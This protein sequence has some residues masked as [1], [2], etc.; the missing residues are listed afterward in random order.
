MSFTVQVGVPGPQGPPGPTGPAS[1][2]GGGGGATGPTGPT[3]PD[4]ANLYPQIGT[5]AALQS[6]S[7]WPGYVAITTDT[8]LELSNGSTWTSIDTPVAVPVLPGT[9]TFAT[10]PSATSKPN[11]IAMTTDV[12]AV[13]SNGAMWQPLYNPTNSTIGIAA[14]SP[15]APA[16]TSVPYAIT[17]TASQAVGAPVWSIVFTIG[18]NTWVIDS[19]SGVL[20]GTPSAA[21]TDVVQV[22]VIDASGAS[23]QKAFSITVAASLTPAATPTFAPTAGSYTGSQSVAISCS[24]AS[25][26][27]YYTV[28]GSTPTTSSTVYT[29]PITVAVTTTIQAIA[30]ASGFTQSAVGFSAYTITVPGTTYKFHPGDY[31]VTEQVY[32]CTVAQAMTEID[33]LALHPFN[34]IGYVYGHAWYQLDTAT[35]NL[36]NP[37]NITAQFGGF[38]DIATV[39]NYLQSKIPGARFGCYINANASATSVT[40]SNIGSQNYGNGFPMPKWIANCSGSLAMPISYG[41]ATT[42]T[43]SV[44]QARG[45]AGFYGFGFLGY[46]G[47]THYAGYVAA[48]W[49]PA[50]NQAW[51]NMWEALSKWSFTVTAGPLS[52]QT[53]TLDANSL[54]E[55]L[56]VND[57]Y[58]YN[59]TSSQNAP[60]FTNNPPLQTSAANSATAANYFANHKLWAQKAT[61]FFPHTMIGL[62]DSFGFGAVGPSDTAPVMA[63]YINNAINGN[64]LST[65]Q[66][67]AYSNSDVYGLDWSTGNNAFA[68]P[69]KQGYEGI[70]AAQYNPCT[71][72]APTVAALKGIMPILGQVQPQDYGRSTGT[73]NF[74]AAAVNALAA[75]MA[76]DNTTHRL[77]GMGDSST[78]GTVAW[79]SYAG[80]AVAALAAPTSTRPSN[81]P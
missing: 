42:V 20:S 73:T 74:T 68:T 34:T 17:L 38:A 71:L 66:G 64:G 14:N 67:L 47:G 24:T 2:G 40:I 25:P 78:F 39:F 8:G 15:L 30:T 56:G 48:L 51:I 75:S 70:A 11:V 77:W 55:F 22:Q 6:P 41:N 7:L 23:T 46:D 9:F 44:A 10:L 35:T 49:D 63:G 61:S 65:I 76:H 52:G 31:A 16:Q 27:I 50:V 59:L 57:E 62:C 43:S 5:F 58:S 81:L 60:G 53:L 54:V 33:V 1:G 37:A 3:G 12:G 4:I 36:N 32:R 19:A 80:A 79:T 21:Q 45:T 13:Q 69:A 18:T 29:G 72:N 26:T 28:N